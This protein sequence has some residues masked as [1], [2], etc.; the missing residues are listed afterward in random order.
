M[1]GAWFKGSFKNPIPIKKIWQKW[2]EYKNYGIPRHKFASNSPFSLRPQVEWLKWWAD[3][4]VNNVFEIGANY[5]Q[6][7][8]ILQYM[9]KLSDADVWAFEAHPDI[10]AEAQKLYSFNII[11]TAVSNR[12]GIIEFNCAPLGMG[13]SS[14]TSSLRESDLWNY[15]KKIQVDA[16]RMDDF[17]T[18]KNIKEIGFLK[19]DVEGC[20]YEVL[21]GF[22]TR[23]RDVKAIHVEHEHKPVWEGQ[24]L[25]E[26][27]EKLLKENGFIMVYFQRYNF[28]SD[29]FWVQNS[30]IKEYHSN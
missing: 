22:G 29:S 24:K 21:E 10:V 6:D 25:F 1:L 4:Q 11:N 30:C 18:A 23:L 28:Q 17:L 13:S 2:R 15:E 26:D 20:S 12:V 27:I 9:F 14:G 19:I 16:I 7:A 5:C 3:I 8:A